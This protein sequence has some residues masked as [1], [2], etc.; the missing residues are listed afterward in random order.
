[1]ITHFHVITLFIKITFVS[2]YSYEDTIPGSNLHETE[3]S[4]VFQP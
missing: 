3:K 2:H 1:M 4:A